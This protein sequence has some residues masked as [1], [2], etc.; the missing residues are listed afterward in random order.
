MH[1]SRNN[2]EL[3]NYEWISISFQ[4]I[5]VIVIPALP[6]ISEKGGEDEAQ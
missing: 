3:L 5:I 1:Q 4:L 6:W 2:W